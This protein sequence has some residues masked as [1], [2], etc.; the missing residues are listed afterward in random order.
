MSSW[1][2]MVVEFS[3][4]AG[5]RPS[6]QRG[7]IHSNMYIAVTAGSDK[8]AFSVNILLSDLSP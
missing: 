4:K 8:L 3:T 1:I 7:L 5:Y 2:K 6:V